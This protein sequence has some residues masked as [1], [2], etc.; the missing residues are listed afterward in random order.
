MDTRILLKIETEHKVASIKTIRQVAY[1]GLY[2][3]K[4]AQ[5]SGMIFSDLSNMVDFQRMFLANWPGSLPPPRF[6][7]ERVPQM[8]QDFSSIKF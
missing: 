5:E 3:A 2:E 4:V 8:P 1:I 6:Y 7:V